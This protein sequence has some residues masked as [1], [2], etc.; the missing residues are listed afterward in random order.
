[1]G[2]VAGHEYQIFDTISE[3]TL[4]FSGRLSRPGLPPG[5]ERHVPKHS[6]S[7]EHERYVCGRA[8]IYIRFEA[9]EPFLIQA[10]LIVEIEEED[11]KCCNRLDDIQYQSTPMSN[12]SDGSNGDDRGQ[13]P[14]PRRCVFGFQKK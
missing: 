11:H 13:S 6:Y 4:E 7:M 10:S 12:C 2:R 8:H 9:A 3:Q 1:M 5:G 14:R